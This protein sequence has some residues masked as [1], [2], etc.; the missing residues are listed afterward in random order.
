MKLNLKLHLLLPMVVVAAGLLTACANNPGYNSISA[1]G[2]VTIP[3][4]EGGG[5]Y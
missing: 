3:P 4:S 2:S 1:P 5:A